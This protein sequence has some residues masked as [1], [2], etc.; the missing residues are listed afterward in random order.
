MQFLKKSFLIHI[1]TELY[2]KITPV[3]VAILN[4]QSIQKNRKFVAYHTRKEHSK[5]YSGFRERVRVMMFDVT[6]IF[7][8]YS[9]GGFREKRR[10]S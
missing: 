6:T 8:L 3:I 10:K 7:E 2:D 1:L 4:F 5:S 9:G